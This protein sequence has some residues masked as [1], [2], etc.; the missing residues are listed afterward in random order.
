MHTSDAS[1][2][3]VVGYFLRCDVLD[4][5]GGLLSTLLSLTSAPLTEIRPD[6]RPALS[7]LVPGAQ[8]N[9]HNPFSWP[10][11]SR[12]YLVTRP[13]HHHCNVI[14][15]LLSSLVSS[16][17]ITPGRSHSCEE[18]C[19]PCS[20]LWRIENFLSLFTSWSRECG[21]AVWAPL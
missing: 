7:S 2:K 9:F 12:D 5:T 15:A 10:L 6:L 20:S 16:H 21:A 11:L 14:F 3:S 18:Y 1:Q 13:S 19:F 17:Y 8:C 4:R